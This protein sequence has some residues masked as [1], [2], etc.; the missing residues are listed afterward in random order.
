MIYRNGRAANRLYKRYFSATG[1]R[2]T[3]MQKGRVE[4]ICYLFDSF[5]LPINSCTSIRAVGPPTRYL[6]RNFFG[7]SYCWFHPLGDAF[8]MLSYQAVSHFDSQA[9]VV[10]RTLSEAECSKNRWLKIGLSGVKNRKY[11]CIYFSTEMSQAR[12]TERCVLTGFFRHVKGGNFVASR[13]KH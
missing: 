3:C 12:F 6:L 11:L 13:K 1:G 2:I 5:C 9:S 7:E 8:V 4:T 10:T